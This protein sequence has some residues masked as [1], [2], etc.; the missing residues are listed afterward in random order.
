VRGGLLGVDLG[1]R[2]LGFRDLHVG[3]SAFEGRARRIDLRAIRAIVELRKDL[4]LAHRV[5]EVGRQASDL[6]GQL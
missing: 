6:P 4:T 3:L 2:E 5:V 1:A